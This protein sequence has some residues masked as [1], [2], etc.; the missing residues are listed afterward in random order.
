MQPFA[1]PCRQPC[2][3]SG[4]DVRVPTVRVGVFGAGGQWQFHFRCANV[5]D[6]GRGQSPL[7][8]IGFDDMWQLAVVPPHT[9]ALA[10]R[11]LEILRTRRSSIARSQTT[12]G[13]TSDG[14][15]AHVEILLLHD[16]WHNRVLDKVQIL[17]V[18][19]RLY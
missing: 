8:C 11:P 12:V 10:E 16:L 9:G 13:S 6:D 2:L 5:H 7:L 1:Q 17:V 15:F 4:V 18:P 3:G 14:D 19:A